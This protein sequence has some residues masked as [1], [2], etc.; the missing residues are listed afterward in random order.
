MGTSMEL[1]QKAINE[2]GFKCPSNWKY[3]NLSATRDKDKKLGRV[4]VARNLMAG[5]EKLRDYCHQANH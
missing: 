2:R 5:Q 1:G 3:S 4:L